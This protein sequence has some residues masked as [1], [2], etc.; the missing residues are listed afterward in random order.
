MA[1]E[2][3]IIVR[4]S[5]LYEY[6]GLAKSVLTTVAHL[7]ISEPKENEQGKV[8]GERD[9]NAGWCVAGE[10]YLAAALGCSSDSISKH[11]SLIRKDGWLEVETWRNRFGHPH[12]K[13]R[14]PAHKL[15]EI[16]A[17]AYKKDESGNIIR[18]T[19]ANKSRKMSRGE[20]GKFIGQAYGDPTHALGTIDSRVPS[21]QSA[22]ELDGSQ[23]S[24]LTAPCGRPHGSEPSVVGLRMLNEQVVGAGDKKTTRH[25]DSLHTGTEQIKVKTPTLSGREF[26]EAIGAVKQPSPVNS[27][28]TRP[29][30]AAPRHGS[31][32]SGNKIK[33]V[34][35]FLNC[36]GPLK[37]NKP[38]GECLKCKMMP[39]LPVTKAD[40]K[41]EEPTAPHRFTSRDREAQC[42]NPGCD[43]TRMESLYDSSSKFCYHACKGG[44]A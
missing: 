30:S 21:R 17:R 19:Q 6:K 1:F 22:E 42:Q 4:N 27:S 39:L 7:I 43:V 2:H 35:K 24:S 18:G 41:V 28:T 26:A 31:E 11:V 15:E 16:K 13:Y 37:G 23:P 20:K 36:G 34:C 10:E 5:D 44:V 38:E 29:R 9:P 12:N 3:Y 8:I 14:I 25:D 40:L 32:P 33:L